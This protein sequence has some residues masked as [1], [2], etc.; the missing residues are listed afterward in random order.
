[1]EAV[2]TTDTSVY[3]NTRCHR[4]HKVRQRST[5]ACP[6]SIYRHGASSPLLATR[7]DQRSVRHGGST[8]HGPFSIVGGLS[9]HIGRR[10]SA[11][12][13][14]CNGADETAEHLV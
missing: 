12:C 14:H 13:P 3:F 8:V 11:T 5:H 6:L 2:Y 10:D 9:D 7:L 4:S 1:M